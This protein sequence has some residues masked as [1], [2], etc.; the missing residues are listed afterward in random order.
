MSVTPGLKDPSSYS[1]ELFLCFVVLLRW[2]FA[3]DLNWTCLIIVFGTFTGMPV[4]QQSM[5]PRA[6]QGVCPRGSSAQPDPEKYQVPASSQRVR[7]TQPCPVTIC[8]RFVCNGDT[9][10]SPLH[11]I[12]KVHWPGPVLLHPGQGKLKNVW[13]WWRLQLQWRFCLMLVFQFNFHLAPKS[14][15]GR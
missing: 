1:T 13:T 3:E 7:A 2:K 9:L 5:Q 12:H 15:S 6:H 4:I 14:V 8:R 10:V 11:D